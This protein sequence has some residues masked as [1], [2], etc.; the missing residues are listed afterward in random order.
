[1]DGG[2]GSGIQLARRDG[3]RFAPAVWMRGS[4]KRRDVAA[5]STSPNGGPGIRTLMSLRTPV[6]KTGA[7]AILPTLP[8]LHPELRNLADRW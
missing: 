7:I 5:V 1:M 8:T 3:E 2:H 6:F 4:R